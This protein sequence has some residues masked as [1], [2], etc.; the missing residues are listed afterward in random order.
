M[1][2]YNSNEY[3]Q[4]SLISTKLLN[5]IDI[6]NHDLVSRDFAEKDLFIIGC[7]TLVRYHFDLQSS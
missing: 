3:E 7:I 4:P 5:I 2:D 1:M 6:L